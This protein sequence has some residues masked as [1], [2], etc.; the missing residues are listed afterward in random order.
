MVKHGMMVLGFLLTIGVSVGLPANSASASGYV[1]EARTVDEIL[2]A[3]DYND[4]DGDTLRL[5]RAFFNR[6]PDANGAVYWIAQTRTGANMDDLAYGF[7]QSTE[8]NLRY[9]PV[10][11]GEFL[12]LLYRN[13]LGRTADAKGRKYW[14]DQMA[15][16]LSQD[17]VVRWVVANDEFIRR[18]PYSPTPPTDPG[19]TKNCSDFPFHEL[20]QAWFDHHFDLYGDVSRLDE[21]NDGIACESLPR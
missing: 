20:A 21:N 14:L 2:H 8:F 15:N 6:E 13:I 19:D 4:A 12:D 17:G 3:V 5:Y 9:G 16:G 1:F 18:H 11:N 10:D 7:A